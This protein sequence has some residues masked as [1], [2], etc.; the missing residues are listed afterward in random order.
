[1]EYESAYPASRHLR[2]RSARLVTISDYG[3]NLAIEAA[4]FPKKQMICCQMGPEGELVGT[5][6]FN[7]DG[8]V[9]PTSVCTN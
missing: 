9:T 1:M 6:R 2:W 4:L 7:L 8:R 5:L 3:N